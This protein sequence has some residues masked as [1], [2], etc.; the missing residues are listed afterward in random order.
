[1]PRT[2]R[3]AAIL[4]TAV[5]GLGAAATGL[6]TTATAATPTP[7]RTVLSTGTA[8]I[9][10]GQ[11][12]KVKAVVKPVGTTGLPTGNVTFKE[13]A[14]TFGT[15]ALATVNGVQ[16]ATLTINGLTVGTHMVTATYAGTTAWASS[17][18]LPV[19]ITVSKPGTTTTIRASKN[20]PVYTVG[21]VVQL[22]S[23]VKPL[24]GTGVPTGTVTF[25]SGG[26]VVGTATLAVAP[27]T[28]L[29][30][31]K[32][33]L[34]GVSGGNHTY[35][36]AYGGNTAYGSSVSPTPL[37]VTVN[38]GASSTTVT[39][40]TAVA[41]NNHRFNIK[42]AAVAPATGVPTGT[43]TITVTGFA[44]QILALSATGTA[45]L[46]LFLA[47]GPYTASVTYSGDSNFNGSSGSVT[48]TQ[49]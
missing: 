9:S 48:W 32:L 12:A 35:T 43:V 34:S 40:A 4:A 11:A 46:S 47:P 7:T 44:Q 8:N 3:S 38:K 45:H 1:M 13:G 24:V 42:V 14:T 27:S 26:N 18:S 10:S 5:I 28:G 15:S 36:A 30:T 22:I 25:S 16:T 39:N 17:T 20:P 31:A 49:P 19:T 21:Q 2:L 29:A 33:S 37:T 41:P 6:A 23:V